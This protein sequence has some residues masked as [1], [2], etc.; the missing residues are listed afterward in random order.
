MPH[1]PAVMGPGAGCPGTWS[2]N[3]AVA[4]ATVP[5][6]NDGTSGSPRNG[7]RSNEIG[8]ALVV[9]AIGVSESI[10]V[11]TLLDSVGMSH[12]GSAVTEPSIGTRTVLLPTPPNG[13]KG[14][15]TSGASSRG[16]RKTSSVE[17]P[18]FVTLTLKVLLVPAGIETPSGAPV[19]VAPA[20][21]LIRPVRP[22]EVSLPPVGSTNCTTSSQIPE[23]ALT[24][25]ASA[26]RPTV[27]PLEFFAAM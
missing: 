13:S 26:V 19:T 17:L 11:V 16:S 5:G 4:L 12:C 8:N 9:G 20:V 1:P 23:V 25:D 15:L 22:S 14:T 7:E 21:K 3:P 24:A 27:N 10:L 2:E 6:P 18:L